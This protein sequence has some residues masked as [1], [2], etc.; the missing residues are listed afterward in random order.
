MCRKGS[1]W[2]KDSKEEHLTVEVPFEA[3]SNLK[4]S[5]HRVLGGTPL[6]PYVPS[7]ILSIPN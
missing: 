7:T 3:F 5:E 2:W 6:C 4:I 1:T